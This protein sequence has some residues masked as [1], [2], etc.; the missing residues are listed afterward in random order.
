MCLS[1]WR[2]PEPAAQIGK[3][4]PPPITQKPR[5]KGEISMKSVLKP[6]F[7]PTA[8]LLISAGLA[9]EVSIVTLDDLAGPASHGHTKLKQ[10]LA[11]AGLSVAVSKQIPKRRPGYVLLIGYSSNDKV[12]ALVRKGGLKLPRKEQSLAVARQDQD[13]Q[14][15]LLIT[16]ADPVGLMYAQL[17]VAQRVRWAR[18]QKAP[19]MYVTSIYEE[20]FLTE[21][22]VSTYTMQRRWFEQ[23]LFDTEYWR[24]YFDLLAESRINSFVIIFGYECGGF[25][26]PMYPYF[27][28]VPRFEN[29]RIPGL[30]RNGTLLL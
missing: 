7:I 17:D 11:D 24:R 19:L 20:P 26:A 23:R 29:V 6:L 10:A 14:T 4:L 18:G 16:G 5:R 30:S 13:G 22:G 15:L 27:F 2:V 12:A 3:R 28:D 8:S 25:M 9:E 1:F 21:R